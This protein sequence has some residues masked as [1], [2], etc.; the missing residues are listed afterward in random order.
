[1]KKICA[2]LTLGFV[3]Q[4]KGKSFIVLVDVEQKLILYLWEKNTESMYGM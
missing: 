4:T 3:R 1:M 2:W